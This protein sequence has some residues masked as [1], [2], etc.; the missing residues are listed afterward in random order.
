M[1][2][3][4]VLGMSGEVL[5]TLNRRLAERQAI[6]DE[7]LDALKTSHQLRWMLFETAKQVYNKPVTLQMLASM[8]D[9]LETEQQ[10]LWNFPADPNY[11]RFFDFPGC[12]CPKMDNAEAMGTQYRIYSGDCSIHGSVPKVS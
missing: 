4:D 12:K 6:T 2:S 9:A 8:F 5:T 10:K 11:H 1:R 7:Q 3:Y